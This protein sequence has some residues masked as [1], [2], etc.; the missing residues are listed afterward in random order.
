M[1][2]VCQQGMQRNMPASGAERPGRTYEAI[3]TAFGL[4]ATR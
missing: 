4:T 1:L 2:G 3:V